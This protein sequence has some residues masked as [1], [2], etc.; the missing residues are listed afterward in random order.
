MVLRL[1]DSS[2]L[3]SAI[4]F[5]LTPVAFSKASLFSATS[6]VRTSISFVSL[7][8]SAVNPSMAA[9]KSAIACSPS[10]M[11]LVFAFTP[12][13]HCLIHFLIFLG[14]LLKLLH[15]VFQ[16]GDHFGHWP[17]RFL[18]RDGKGRRS[19][20]RKKENTDQLHADRLCW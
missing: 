5:F 19:S 3:N 6:F 1:A 12:T 8:L 11:A 7:E 15:H 20:E 10:A 17:S 16:K 13:R 18:Y 2:S 9:V 4:S 14:F